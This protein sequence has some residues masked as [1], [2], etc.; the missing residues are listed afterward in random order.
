MGFPR[1][2]INK[3]KSCSRR[4]PNSDFEIPNLSHFL[5]Q[6]PGALFYSFK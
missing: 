4:I 5:C 6:F 3:S 2:I 1:I